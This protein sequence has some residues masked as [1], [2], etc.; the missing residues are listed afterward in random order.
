V[1][2]KVGG[3][4]AQTPA[5]GYCGC[6]RALP[7]INATPRLSEIKVPALVICGEQDMGTPPAMAKVIHEGIKGSE[8]ALIP[9]AAHLSN[10]EQPAKF[11]AAVEKFYSR[12]GVG[13]PSPEARDEDHPHRR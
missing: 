13:R 10:M 4:I 1:T 2:D 7:K 9:E 11:L 8:L 6:G 12:I 3:W 5:D